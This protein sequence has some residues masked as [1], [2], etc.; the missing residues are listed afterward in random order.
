MEQTAHT[1]KPAANTKGRLN[2]PLLLALLLLAAG[3]GVVIVI[4]LG[5][6]DSSRA[7]FNL[8]L[9]RPPVD[10]ATPAGIDASGRR[11]QS[12]SNLCGVGAGPDCQTEIEIIRS[13]LFPSNGGPTGASTEPFCAPTL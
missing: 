2:R 11:L 9:L 13:R 8:P 6:S 10:R 12:G 5:S 3:G 7:E 4:V 1:D